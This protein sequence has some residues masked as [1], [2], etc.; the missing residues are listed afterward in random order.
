MTDIYEVLS[1]IMGY[2]GLSIANVAKKCGLSDST[3]RG[4]ITR[5]QK[6]VSLEVA[7]K[8][9]DGLG[10]SLERLNGIDENK[11]NKDQCY[12]DS[13]ATEKEFKQIIQPYRSLDEYG[14]ETVRILLDRESG[15]MKEMQ[16][17]NSAK[18]FSSEIAP[19]KDYLI[20]NAA[21]DKVGATEEEKE[22]DNAYMDD[23]TIWKN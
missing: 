2:E 18:E 1:E 22:A 4:I 12:Y 15:R 6:T 10:V 8:I 9:A 23:E 5:K 7:F 14:K 11:E 16:K 20:A 19:D 17:K 21:H 3:V 13:H